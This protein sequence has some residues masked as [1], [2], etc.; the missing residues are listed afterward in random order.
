MKMQDKLSIAKKKKKCY[1]NK[2]R[3]KETKMANGIT[4]AWTIH[5]TMCKDDK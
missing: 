5:G 4:K 1:V 2:S 3:I